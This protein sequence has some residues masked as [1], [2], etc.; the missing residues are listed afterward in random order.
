MVETTNQYRVFLYIFAIIHSIKLGL[1][2]LL[3]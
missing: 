2:S 3:R 1:L